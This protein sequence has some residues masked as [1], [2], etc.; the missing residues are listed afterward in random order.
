MTKLYR[1]AT[2][3]KFRAVG[4]APE[5]ANVSWLR[6]VDLPVTLRTEGAHRP[7]QD[8]EGED[9]ADDGAGNERLRRLAGPPPSY[10]LSASHYYY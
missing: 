7:S 5:G 3:N 4:I 10:P 9:G 6:A 8:A 1:D 2:R